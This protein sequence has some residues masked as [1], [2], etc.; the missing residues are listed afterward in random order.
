M[1]TALYTGDILRVQAK[2]F[3]QKIT[4]KD[5]FCASDGW[6]DTFKKRFDIHL[7]TILGKKLSSD[8]SEVVSFVKIFQKKV[9][10]GPF[11]DLFLPK[12]KMHQ[13]GK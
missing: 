3:Y 1:E 6:L 8:E 7:I 11:Q 2:E 9:G 4:G 13:I 12:N 5:E 10:V